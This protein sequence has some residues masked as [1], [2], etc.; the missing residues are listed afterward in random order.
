MIERTFNDIPEGKVSE[1]DQH[2]FLVGLG[3]S[4]GATWDDLLRSKRI[5]MISEAGAGKTY[6]CSTKAQHLWNAGEPAFFVELAALAKEDLRGL[7]DPEEKIRLDDWV[8]SQSAVATFFLDSFDELK[9]TFGSF[10]LALKRLKNCIGDQLHRAR[11]VITTRPIPFDER[12]VR[13]ILP[14]PPDYSS[15]PRED[16]FAK[17]AMRDHLQQRDDNDIDPS[18]TWRTV[19]LMPLSDEQI[20]EFSR[21]QGVNDPELLLEDLKNR[22]A[23]EFARRPQ[24]LIELSADWREHKLIRTHRD[25]V[26]T[27]IRVKLLPRNNRG[28][29]AELSVDKAIEG[30][31][32]LALAMHMTR[33][34]TIRHSA[35]ADVVYGEAALNPEIILPDWKPNERKALLER[36]LFGFASYGRVRFHHRSVAEYLAAERLLTLRKQGMSFR[37]LKRLLFAETKGKTIVRPSKRPVA[38]WLALKEIGVFELLRDNEPDVLLNEGD[39]ESLTQPQRNQAL[40]AYSDRYGQGGWRGLRV[41]RI[42]VRR[43]ASKELADEIDRIWQSGVENPDVRE[44]LISLIEAGRIDDCADI[45]F[46]V[47][48]DNEASVAERIEALDALVALDDKRLDEIV[49][50][51]VAADNRWSDKVA[52]RAILRLFP[53]HMSVDQLCQVLRWIRPKEDRVDDLAWQLGWIITNSKLDYSIVAELRDGIAALICDGLK[54][55][56]AWPHI[57]SDRSNLIEALAATCE[58]GLDVCQSGKW[59][60]A[61]VLSLRLHNRNYGNGEWINLLRNRLANFNADNTER[62]FW[63]ADNLLQSLKNNHPR[64]RYFLISADDGPVKLKPDR[65]LAWVSDSLGDKKRDLDER[66]MLLEA[67]LLLKRDR[68]KR[69]KHAERLKSLVDDE[70][71]L[72]KRIDEWLKQSKLEKEGRRRE[73]QMAKQKKKE[74]RRKAEYRKRCMLLWREISNKPEDAFSPDRRRHTAWNLWNVMRD[75]SN[76]RRS[77]AGWNRRFIEGH[78][79]KET[80]DRFRRVLMKIWRDYLPTSPSKR[81]KGGRNTL[82]MCWQLGLAAI[83]AEAEDSDWANKICDEEARSAA[84]FAL[85]EPDSFPQWI[86][87]LS[88]THPT[89]VEKTLGN[90]LFWELKQ[91]PGAYGNLGVLQRINYASE[92]VVQL[93]LPHLKAWLNEDGDQ[94]GKAVGV[95]EKVRQVTRIILQHDEAD[96]IARLKGT[97]LQRLGQQLPRELRLVWLTTLMHIDP[98]AGV[99]RLEDQIKAVKPAKSSDAVTWFA[100]L[101][102]DHWNKINLSDEGFTPQVLLRLLRL[103]YR[104]VRIQDDVRHKWPPFLDLRPVAERVRDSIVSAL[105]DTKGEEGWA[106]KLELAADPLCLHL[107]D[108][109]LAVAEEKWAQEIDTD[110]LDDQQAVALEN[111]LEAPVLTSEAM[112]AIMKDRLYGLKDL[113]QRDDSP[114]EAWAGIKAEKAMRRVIALE[115]RHSANSIYIV[116]QEAATVDEKKTDIRLCS[117]A[118]DHEAV[119]EIKTGDRRF[120]SAKNLRDAIENQLA[121]KYM[122]P[123]NR[124]SGALLVTLAENREWQHPDGKVLID[125]NGL[126]SLLRQEAERVEEALGGDVRIAVH[127]LDLR[128]RLP[129]ERKKKTN[130]AKNKA[131]PIS[132]SG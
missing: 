41:P 124:R 76:D 110:A 99:D 132:F 92:N 105:L 60:D 103:A 98:S 93:L 127:F 58:R 123:E 32:R 50:N 48:C 64:K 1:A 38:G 95:A 36:P 68:S 131:Y 57:A 119:I 56:N 14:V 63:A 10:E 82:P 62:L 13:K 122:T 53:K 30:A 25:Q 73:R 46:Q 42:Q 51:I 12:L 97:A 44:V 128:P 83:Y 90:E 39:P 7:L 109:I 85:I 4:Q 33:R 16:A 40:R 106:A 100:R 87:A 6:E 18:P 17:I 107:K 71:S 8:S 3:W 84:R 116:D 81:L 54:W 24:D 74:K 19:A 69:R 78:F 125:V 47:A 59:F 88:A 121:K 31:S 65:D 15:E 96:A 111:N 34:L 75:E 80:A 23:Q 28:E 26:A 20:V 115:L 108:R 2:S 89:A 29:P 61:S 49:A 70:P 22:N 67:A 130:K 77:S 21:N 120:T 72:V 129:N 45:V 118:S 9:L 91:A 79:D 66:S 126:I 11:V 102:G 94:I 86:E 104:H 112:F 114:R 37:A 55:T 43:F 5:L 52:R 117:T 27:N 113:L 35:E 101:F